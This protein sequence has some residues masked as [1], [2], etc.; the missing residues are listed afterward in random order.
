MC[1]GPP[2]SRVHKQHRA[3]LDKPLTK[4]TTLNDITVTSIATADAAPTLETSTL[5][6]TE[7]AAQVHSSLEML[8]ELYNYTHWLFNKVRP[9]IR[10]N[11]CE[12]GC[13]IGTVTQFLLNNE[14]IVGIEPFAGSYEYARERFQDHLN[15]RIVRCLLESCPNNAVRT[16]VFDT[17]VCLNVLEHLEDDVASLRRMAM[18]CKAGG[19]VVI[20][21]PAH[22]C[23]YGE[24]DRSFGHFRRY[25]RRSLRRAFEVAGLRPTY[26]TYMNTLG[27]G[28]WWWQSRIRGHRQLTVKSSRLFNRLVPFLDAFERVVRLPFG[29]SL[30]MVG[31][32]IQPVH[33]NPYT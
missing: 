18:L 19:R 33:R 17:V 2:E 20:L 7:A 26:S 29:Q 8:G 24:L 5:R 11:I 25:N 13:G 9:F 12:V 31:T 23:V 10:G 15:V 1:L 27:L 22:M 21:V 3:F 28:G 32:P 14:R 16:G 6:E 30:I 4:M